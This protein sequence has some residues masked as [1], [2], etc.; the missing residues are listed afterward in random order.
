MAASALSMS[1]IGNSAPTSEYP[2]E[3]V[4]RLPALERQRDVEDRREFV[5]VVDRLTTE[6]TFVG[7]ERGTRSTVEHRR[8]FFPGVE[9]GGDLGQRADRE[10]ARQA[11]RL[12]EDS[13]HELGRGEQ[14]QSVLGQRRGR[15]ELAAGLDGVARSIANAQQPRPVAIGASVVDHPHEPVEVATMDQRVEIVIRREVGRRPSA[16]AES[17][18]T[19]AIRRAA[20]DSGDRSGRSGRP[21]P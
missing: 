2:R 15:P 11:V 10:P 4:L 9:L 19:A 12:V 21:V 17:S 14:R 1:G 3:G 16:G 6:H 7:D 20:T 13:R 5:A 18:L 8:E